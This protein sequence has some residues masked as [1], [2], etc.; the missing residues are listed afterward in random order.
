MCTPLP[1]C[2][3][4][5]SGAK[6]ARA[7]ARREISRTTSLNTTA[8][9]ALAT[10]S[11]GATGISNWCGA[12]SAKNRSGSTPASTSAPITCAGNGS[13][14]R[15]A[16]SVNGS[17]GAMSAE[18]GDARFAPVPEPAEP[19]DT[20][21]APVPEPTSSWNSC[22]KLATRRASSVRSS[23]PRASRRKLRGQHSHG[24][25]AVSTMSHSISSSA[26]C[27]RPRR[28][29]RACLHPAAAAGRRSSRTDS[30]RRRDRAA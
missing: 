7:P 10:P 16:S 28:R 12:Y 8:R 1:A 20:R 17:A 13:T 2:S 18:P 29:A 11:V 25:P 9:S 19:G 6:L 30:A 22:S 23:S 14:R 26:L 4:S 21:F 24:C 3:G 15:C 5:S 27:S